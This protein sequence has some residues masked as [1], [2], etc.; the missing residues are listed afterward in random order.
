MSMPAGWYDDGSGRQRWWDGQKWTDQFASGGSATQTPPQIPNIGPDVAA[1]SGRVAPV[2]GFAGLGLAVVG[3]VLACIP[4]TFIVGVVVLIAA[5]VVSLI[6]LFK[7]NAAKWPSIVGMVLSI[8]GGAIGTV[9]SLVIVAA[10][11][12]GPTDSPGPIDTPSSTSSESSTAAP[13]TP[14]EPSSERPTPEELAIELEILS[15]EGGIVGYEDDPAFYPCVGQF[16]YDSEL[17]DESLRLIMEGDDPLDAERDK[18]QELIGQA[19][20]S[21]ES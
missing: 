6:G 21:C 13:S 3:T 17:S 4:A 19:V 14:Q 12:A 7:K 20:S 15:K 16:M 8:V 10:T 1:T 2:L 9:V 11:L 18:A 5:F